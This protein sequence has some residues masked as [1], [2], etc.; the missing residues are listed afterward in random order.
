MSTYADLEA[1]FK[2]RIGRRGFTVTTEFLDEMIAAQEELEGMPQLPKFLK[3][4]T[5]WETTPQGNIL[6]TNLPP[7]DFIRVYD[8]Q[9]LAYLAEDGKEKHAKRLDTRNQLVSKR[10]A[11]VSPNG[12]IYYYIDEM[13]GTKY[14]EISHAQDRDVQWRLTYYA[15]DTILT[16]ANSNLWCAREP[17]Q[18]LGFAGMNLATWLRDERAL[19]YYQGLYSSARS[20][21]IRQIEADEWGDTD[22]VMG[23]PD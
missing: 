4:Q 16:G 21:M 9:A 19:K 1:R 17:N 10:N 13:G 12:T 14:I 20:K 22:L 5:L 2:R 23:D 15:Q 3:A 6:L 8:D 7:A 11:G 18:I